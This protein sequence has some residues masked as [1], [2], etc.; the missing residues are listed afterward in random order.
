MSVTTRSEDKAAT[1]TAAP[2]V[3]YVVAAI[4]TARPRQWL[5]NLLVFA[6]PMASGM[7]LDYG[8]LQIMAGTFAAFTLA[9]AACY[10][11]NDVMDV[12]QDRDHPS[13]CRRPVAAG[14]FP[15][16]AALFTAA[17]EAALAFVVAYAVAGW[18]LVGVVAGYLALQF[19]YSI[20]LKQIA[21]VDI[22]A[23]ALG[24]VLRTIA[25][26]VAVGLAVTSWFLIVAF[27]GALFVVTG[28]RH[29]EHISPRSANRKRRTV[30]DEY[31][32]PFYS[33]VM[34]L[35]SAVALVTYCIWAFQRE[36]RPD[37]WLVASIFPFGTALLRYS[38][39]V[40]SGDGE[41]PEEVLLRD[42]AMLVLGAVWLVM[43]MIGLHAN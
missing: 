14:L 8:L 32:L 27:F 2:A 21:V 43:A 24:F 34:T 10:S 38:L 17:M 23:V 31:V 25:G 20:W 42:Q 37:F 26:A 7:A 13:K 11:V 12:E 28:K 30:L 6:V 41:A 15:V 3:S 19:G 40:M 5:K 29:A 9:A 16:G 35:S 1:A 33:H 39:I 36:F 22:V 18:E 4:H